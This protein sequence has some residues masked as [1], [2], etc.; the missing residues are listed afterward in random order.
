MIGRD[1]INHSFHAKKAQV[2]EEKQHGYRRVW[3]KAGG[4]KTTPEA[5]FQEFIGKEVDIDIGGGREWIGK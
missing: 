5:L 3:I 1:K 2:V 4:L